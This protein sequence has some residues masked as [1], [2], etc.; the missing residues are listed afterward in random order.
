M[1]S[2]GSD[3]TWLRATIAGFI[4]ANTVIFLLAALS[5]RRQRALG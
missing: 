3:V 4:A 5:M 2:S 1:S